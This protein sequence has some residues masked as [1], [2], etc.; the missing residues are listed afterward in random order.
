ME[1]EKY[2]SLNII[3]CPKIVYVDKIVRVKYEYQKHISV[4]TGILR[5]TNGQRSGQLFFQNSYL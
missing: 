4:H 1:I 2:K 3:Y 5:S